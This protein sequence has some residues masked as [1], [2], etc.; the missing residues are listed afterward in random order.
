VTR[1]LLNVLWFGLVLASLAAAADWVRSHRSVRELAVGRWVRAPSEASG[2]GRVA[3][4]VSRQGRVEVS[5]LRFS[6]VRHHL[7]GAHTQWGRHGWLTVNNTYP[8]EDL[9]P[10]GAAFAKGSTVNA[11]PTGGTIT[12]TTVRFP[13]WAVVA[14]GLPAPLL[15]LRRRWVLRRR[16]R[17]GLC[18]GCGY[19]L[20][21]S[22][23]RCPECGR[24]IQRLTA[25][26]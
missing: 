17:G 13:H 24:E 7:L 8:L 23:G 22:E 18:L 6:Q 20:R 4:L 11:S 12:A 25:A 14:A 10:P 3:A 21:A 1:W 19:D 5:W 15:V 9:P 26:R 2:D 16:I